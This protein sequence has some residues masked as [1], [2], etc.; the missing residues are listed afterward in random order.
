MQ[1]DNGFTLLELLIALALNLVLSMSAI[2]AL[3]LIKQAWMT[4][5]GIHKIQ[6]NAR[7]IQI[8][9]DNVLQSAG[10]LSC[11]RIHAGLTTWIA[12][13]VDKQIWG[14]A[15]DVVRLVTPLTLQQNQW[16]NSSFFERLI[17]SS[18][19]LWIIS[20]DP[21]AKPV[22]KSN[23]VLLLSDCATLHIFK[24]IEEPRRIPNAEL[25]VL[26]SRLY[27]VGR[28]KRNI[29]QRPIYALYM[30]DFNGY[31]QELFEGVQAMEIGLNHSK[32]NMSVLLDST[33]NKALQKWW[34]FEWNLKY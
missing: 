3:L 5:Q 22:D 7:S 20:S 18:S 11:N 29:N 26:N 2:H 16:L 27:Y 23:Q 1:T 24:N 31:T 34:Y 30:T 25:A 8:Y 19:I 10:R 4:Q 32:M 15:A 14:V 17:S 33:Q 9:F 28:T 6:E 13:T 21:I 12:P